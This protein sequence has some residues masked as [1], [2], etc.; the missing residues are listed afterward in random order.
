MLSDYYNIIIILYLCE[1]NNNQLYV[2]AF[3]F[4]C[5]KKVK[6]TFKGKYSILSSRNGPKN[7]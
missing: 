6:M 5:A 2:V 1:Y 3:T 4:I 7:Q